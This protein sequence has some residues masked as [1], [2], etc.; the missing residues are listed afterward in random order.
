MGIKNCS[1]VHF[2]FVYFML[3]LNKKVKS[4]NF[5]I[6]MACL[7]DLILILPKKKKNPYFKIFSNECKKKKITLTSAEQVCTRCCGLPSP[8]SGMR[9]SSST[10]ACTVST[11]AALQNTAHDTTSVLLQIFVGRNKTVSKTSFY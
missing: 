4:N 3:Y 8:F 10:S 11:S 1:A 6:V 9:Q 2:R 5:Y 7:P